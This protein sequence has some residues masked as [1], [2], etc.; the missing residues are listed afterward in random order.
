MEFLF[1][2]SFLCAC[3]FCNIALTPTK[4]KS[5]IL[6]IFRGSDFKVC[7]LFT[8]P[9]SIYTFVFAFVAQS[10]FQFYDH[11][12]HTSHLTLCGSPPTT[13][14]LQRLFAQWW[15]WSCCTTWLVCVRG[16]V[17]T[18]FFKSDSTQLALCSQ[19]FIIILMNCVGLF[20]LW[21]HVPSSDVG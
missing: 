15:E 9:I 1:S 12:A 8:C 21:M 5:S 7:E 6:D 11:L 10:F 19:P 14:G 3:W 17:I 16:H 13:Y 20:S 4:E 18:M 2:I